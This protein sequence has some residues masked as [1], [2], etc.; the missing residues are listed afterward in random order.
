ME[1][2]LEAQEQMKKVIVLTAHK[3]S[4]AYKMTLYQKYALQE[5]IAQL[6]LISLNHVLKDNINQNMLNMKV[7]LV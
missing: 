5:A 1:K 2:Y 3:V 6:V 7:A 4:I